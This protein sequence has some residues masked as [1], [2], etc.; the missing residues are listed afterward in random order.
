M[1]S[2]TTAAAPPRAEISRTGLDWSLRAL[3]IGHD[4]VSVIA[5]KL[6]VS[7]HTANF[8]ILAEGRRRLINA[9]TRFDGASGIGADEHVWRHTERGDKYVTS[10]STSPRSAR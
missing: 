7:W 2:D 4:T 8:A 3:V 5:S 1:V 9:P 10:S 6:A